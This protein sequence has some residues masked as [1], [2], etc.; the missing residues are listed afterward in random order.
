MSYALGIVSNNKAL[1]SDEAAS[2]A[3]A[4][5]FLVTPAVG[6]ALQDDPTFGLLVGPTPSGAQYVGISP[7]GTTVYTKT[8]T[9]GG[10]SSGVGKRSV[11]AGAQLVP[12]SEMM[13]RLADEQRASVPVTSSKFPRVVVVAICGLL[14]AGGVAYMAT[15]KSTQMAANGRR[16]RLRKNS[17]LG[18]VRDRLAARARDAFARG[19]SAAAARALAELR[20]IDL[21]LM[22]RAIQRNATYAVP[23]R[24]A[25][26]IATAID[27]YHATQRLKQGRVKS[28][29]E[30]R[31][32]V[33]AI[34]HRH[35]DVWRRYLADYPISS[36][37]AS[38]RKGA[39]A[40]RR[41]KNSGKEMR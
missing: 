40:R 2:E 20:E 33:S 6:R 22:P 14:L 9:G 15:R 5:W 24:K 28:A 26:P 18:I 23:E 34:K 8:A 1:V 3:T 11:P 29:A 41:G 27:A 19:D 7:S 30:A 10:T 31:R 12:Y 21:S 39:A 36:I 38:K 13:S 35:P 32:I 16:R 4:R 17:S 25:Y 37:I